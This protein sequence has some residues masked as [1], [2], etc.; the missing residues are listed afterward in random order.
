MGKLGKAL[1]VVASTLVAGLGLAACGDS[2]GSGGG[3]AHE[4]GS[5]NVTLTSFP[6]YLDPQ[7][8]Y[9]LEGWEAPV[10]HLHAP[11]HLQAR[12]R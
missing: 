11:A 5:M 12:E 8:S 2:G 7:L 1:A 4:G 6:D 9:T 3:E 10:E